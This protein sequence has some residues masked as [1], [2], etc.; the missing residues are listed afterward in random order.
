MQCADIEPAA[1]VAGAVVAAVEPFGAK[2][3][4]LAAIMEVPDGK[5]RCRLSGLQQK[6]RLRFWQVRCQQK[7]QNEKGDGARDYH[8]RLPERLKHRQP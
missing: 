1:S 2:P 8:C 7:E 5:N 4:A 3:W 6:A